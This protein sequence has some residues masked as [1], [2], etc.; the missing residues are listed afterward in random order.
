VSIPSDIQIVAVEIRV[1]Q[2]NIIVR[3]S[4]GTPVDIDASRPD[5]IVVH[6]GTVILSADMKKGAHDI[7][8]LLV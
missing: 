3:S 1:T 4:P 2:T 6:G 8:Q 5:R 7:T